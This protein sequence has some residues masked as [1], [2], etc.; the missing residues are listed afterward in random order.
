MRM[1]EQI[2]G[3]Q[4]ELQELRTKQE[5]IYCN[6]VMQATITDRKTGALDALKGTVLLISC[7]EPGHI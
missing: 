7:H 5:N 3:I 1:I 2:D 6:Y 4:R